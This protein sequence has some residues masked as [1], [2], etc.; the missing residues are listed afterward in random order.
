MDV[1]ARSLSWWHGGSPSTDGILESAAHMSEPPRVSSFLGSLG[2]PR[3]HLGEDRA[4]TFPIRE[5]KPKLRAVS[6]ISSLDSYLSQYVPYTS[7]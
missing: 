3:L 1:R 4:S 5:V 6:T 7:N 2:R